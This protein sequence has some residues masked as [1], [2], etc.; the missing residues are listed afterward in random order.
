M[1]RLRLLLLLLTSTSVLL[2]SPGV[3]HASVYAQIE[4]TGS[5]WSQLIVAQWISDVN[6]NGMQVVYTG[7]GSSKGRRDFANDS[8]DF[9]ISEIPYQG[10]DERGQ[11]DTSNGRPSPRATSI[12]ATRSSLKM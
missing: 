7:G 9:A 3:A 4:G 2:G 8:T 1:T 12:A 10:T 6:A 11:A 5:T